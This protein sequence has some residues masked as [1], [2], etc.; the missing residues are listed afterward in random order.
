MPDASERLQAFL[1]DKVIKVL[2]V[3]GPRG[4][5]EPK[6]PQFEIEMLNRVFNL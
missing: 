6:L 1:D 3:A 4:S 2:N 5:K